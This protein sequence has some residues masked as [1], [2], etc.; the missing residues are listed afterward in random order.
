MKKQSS[1]R[2][3]NFACVVY[4][5]SSI[6]NWQDI[7]IEQRIPCFISPLHD[8]DLNP[9]GE[10]KK[11]HYHILLMFDSV[12]TQ[13]QAKEVFDLINGVGCEIVKSIRGYA[14]YLCHLDNPE[15]YQ[16]N[17][18]DVRSLFGAD[19]NN[20]IGLVSDKYL[21]IRQIIT[22]CVDNHIYRYDELFLYA[23]QENDNWYRCLCDN[24]TY[25]I[26]EFLKSRYWAIKEVDN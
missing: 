21:T 17:I 1:V 11:A 22:Y 19:Y 12:K 20:I 5:E 10:P 2:T 26:K 15:K 9:N 25:V 4:P 6:V 3:R 24:G 16:Y 13:S 7:L 23:M 18:D 8:K 14:R